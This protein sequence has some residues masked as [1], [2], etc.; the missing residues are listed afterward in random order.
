MTGSP[1]GTTLD[2]VLYLPAGSRR[3][4]AIIHRMNP[5]ET[6]IGRG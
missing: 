4:L 5:T 3:D 6:G 2:R 1:A